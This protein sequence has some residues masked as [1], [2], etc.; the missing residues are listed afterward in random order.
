MPNVI[1][2]EG[3]YDANFVSN[4]TVGFTEFAALVKT[5]T[6]EW[7][8]PITGI[9]ATP[10]RAVARE[11][12]ATKPA[13]VD[14]WSGPGEHM[15]GAEGSRAIAALAGLIGQRYPDAEHM[16]DGVPEATRRVPPHL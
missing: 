6:P 14:A 4:W 9:S 2:G 7:A 12:A 16:E 11:L 3:L 5:R 15:N 10:I 13:V 1:I 8:A